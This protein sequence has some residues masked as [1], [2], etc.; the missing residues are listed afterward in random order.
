MAEYCFVPYVIFE[1]WKKGTHSMVY[2]HALSESSINIVKIFKGYY[3]HIT[4]LNDFS[5]VVYSTSIWMCS[6]Q[7][8][9]NFEFRATFI[10]FMLVACHTK[11]TR[12]FQYI[13]IWR[14]W[15][16][17]C[18]NRIWGSLWSTNNI[19]TSNKAIMSFPMKFY[20]RLK[21]I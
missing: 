16:L 13:W 6:D 3:V 10:L 21:S 17:I 15:S 1:L 19:H 14:K 12:K 9:E 2:A 18:F 8:Y 5:S 11:N 7:I 4:S 20:H